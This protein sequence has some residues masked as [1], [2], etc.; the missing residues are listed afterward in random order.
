MMMMVEV[1][2]DP[3]LTVGPSVELFTGSGRP[4]GSQTARYAVTANGQR[5]LMSTALLAS[6][7]VGGGGGRAPKVVVVLN[8]TEELKQRVPTN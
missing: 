2:T 5:F 8:W 7:E 4:G 6:G 3:V 1:S